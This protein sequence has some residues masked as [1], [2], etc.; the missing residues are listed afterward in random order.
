L[1]LPA[2]DLHQPPKA[3]S[4]FITGLGI[5]QICSWG[6]LYYSF[7]LVAQAMGDDLGW[8]KTELYSAASIGLA[9]AALAAYPIGAAID[10]GYGRIIMAGGSVMAGLLLMLWSQAGSMALFYVA[11]AGIGAMQAATMYDPAFAVVARRAGPTHARTGITALTMWGGFASTVFIPLIQFMIEHVGWRDTLLILGLINILLCATLNFAVIDP[12]LDAPV[13][14]SAGQHPLAGRV[15]IASVIRRPVFWIL[16][17]TFTAYA[18]AFSGFTFH[19]YPLL[20]ER[21][22]DPHTVVVAIAIIGPAQV[23]GR[24]L[25]WI[26]APRAPV[27]VVGSIIVAVFPVAF[28]ALELAPPHFVVIAF[29]A[30]CFG[31]ANGIM[32]I[33]RGLVVPEMLTRHAYGAVNGALAVPAM[34]ARALAPAGLALLWGAAGSYDAVLGAIIIMAL[35]LATGFWTA[36]VM[37]TRRPVR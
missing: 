9:M 34:I 18:A 21:G 32:T 26:V 28:L 13:S 23:A 8:S 35:I 22:L 24:L 37:S 36:A 16:A 15:A 6:S 3:G 27:R 31:A 29:I 20:V 30:A 33:V 10:R 12:K 25:I 19:L 7:P 17:I 4:A 11:V 5:A 2:D 1:T 14:R